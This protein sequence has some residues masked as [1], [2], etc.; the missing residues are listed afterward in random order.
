MN[1]GKA[2]GVQVVVFGPLHSFCVFVS[3]EDMDIFLDDGQGFF[4]GF[5][6]VHDAMI[7]VGVG[8]ECPH[9]SRHEEDLLLF[10][11]VGEH[12][13][14]VVVVDGGDLV[15]FPGAVHGCE[16]GVWQPFAYFSHQ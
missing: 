8:L 10:V 12:R 1:H 6:D 16:E 15:F 2:L 13:E 5:D 3:G 14:K 11:D 9:L 7:G 4:S